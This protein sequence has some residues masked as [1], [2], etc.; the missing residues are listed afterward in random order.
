LRSSGTAL[1]MS[2]PGVLSSQNPDGNVARMIEIN[3][4][5]NASVTICAGTLAI[6]VLM[7]GTAFAAERP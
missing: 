6:S 7:P 3:A 2:G 4:L 5:C 1:I